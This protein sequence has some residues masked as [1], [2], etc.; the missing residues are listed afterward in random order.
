MTDDVALTFD[1]ETDGARGMC[2]FGVKLRPVICVSSSFDGD[3]L[4]RGV[5]AGEKNAER[6]DGDAVAEFVS[7]IFIRSFALVGDAGITIL[8]GVD[9]RET[10]YA[11][12]LRTELVPSLLNSL[13]EPDA[14][15]SSSFLIAANELPVDLVDEALDTVVTGCVLSA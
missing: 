9:G 10:E 3:R 4:L 13:L 2:L 14:A 7:N 8:L 1:L 12:T 11:P 15:F 5:S 6:S